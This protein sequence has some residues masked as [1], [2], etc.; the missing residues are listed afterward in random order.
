MPKICFRA[1]NNSVD[2]EKVCVGCEAKGGEHD[3][4]TKYLHPRYTLRGL[5]QSTESN[6]KAQ[7]GSSDDWCAKR[8]FRFC[9]FLLLMPAKM[10]LDGGEMEN[11]VRAIDTIKS[12]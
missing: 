9:R 7:R 1:D 2:G 4:N 6:Q 3:L 12:N 11:R 5:W 8:N 10:S